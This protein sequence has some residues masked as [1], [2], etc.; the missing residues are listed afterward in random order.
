MCQRSIQHPLAEH[1]DQHHDPQH[2]PRA[3]PRFEEH[4]Q[5]QL[6]TDERDMLIQST[7]GP[8]FGLG[9]CTP[10]KSRDKQK[11]NLDG[12]FRQE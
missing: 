7:H 5:R 12:R 1:D 6:I 10:P 9:H 11:A 3:G 8:P 2:Q 4:P